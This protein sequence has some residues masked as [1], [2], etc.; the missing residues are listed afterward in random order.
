[1]NRAE[2][3]LKLKE[4]ISSFSKLPVY[5]QKE[6]SN[7]LKYIKHQ[8][9]SIRKYGVVNRNSIWHPQVVFKFKNQ[10]K[11]KSIQ[12]YFET[13]GDSCENIISINPMSV[14]DSRVNKYIQL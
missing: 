12:E 13:Y 2:I 7:T 11:C 1:M 6:N 5:M 14:L 3:T 4:Y 8:Y 10:K 9:N